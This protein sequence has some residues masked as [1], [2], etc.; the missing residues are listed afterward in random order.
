MGFNLFI[1]WPGSTPG[2][3]NPIE[4]HMGK[5]IW[6]VQ[7]LIWATRQGQTKHSGAAILR[8]SGVSRKQLSEIALSSLRRI[9]PRPQFPRVIG[10]PQHRNGR[11]GGG[12]G[13]ADPLSPIGQFTDPIAF[14]PLTTSGTPYLAPLSNSGRNV[15]LLANW[16]R[17]PP[18]KR[19]RKQEGCQS[20]HNSLLTYDFT[21]L[22]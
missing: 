6:N 14:H 11:T 20:A 16:W 7:K 19:I 9:E 1:A 2:E 5:W 3:L 12:K 22:N 8:V 18:E 21:D 10:A 17:S 15:Y 4:H 13:W